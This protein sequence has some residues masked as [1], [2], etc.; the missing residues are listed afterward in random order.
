MK[1]K[2]PSSS[3]YS[4]AKRRHYPSIPILVNEPTMR[5]IGPPGTWSRWSPKIGQRMLRS[6]RIGWGRQSSRDVL[7]AVDTLT[8]TNIG[9]IVATTTTNADIDVLNLIQVGSAQYN[10]VGKVIQ[11]QSV[12][13]FGTITFSLGPVATTSDLIISPLRVALVYDKQP[14]GVLPIF[15]DIFGSIGQTGTEGS[16][17][18]DKLN[19]D[20]TGRFKVIRDW[21]IKPIPGVIS[22]QGTT[23]LN[24]TSYFMDEFVKL[25]K[26]KTN[27][28][29]TSNP[30]VIG[31]IS[32]GG[33]YV[34]MRSNTSTASTCQW[35]CNADF[36]TRLR[37]TD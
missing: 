20:N 3:V 13:L 31:D 2:D 7:K 28:S 21:I 1:R 22:T 29:A 12:R 24:A 37:Y 34:V 5:K 30:A 16:T 18:Y 14:S 33:L 26:L 8:G 9:S 27:F 36:K 25:K 11:M 35:T 10:R 4:A 32:S 15:S 19:L 17:V 23:N 6:R